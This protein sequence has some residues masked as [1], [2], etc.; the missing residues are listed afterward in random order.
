MTD[1]TVD[2]R[3]APLPGVGK[4]LVAQTRY[5]FRL[6]L[7]TP[8]ALT[9]GVGLPVVLLLV[10]NATGGSIDIPHLA[11]LAV[12]G[13]SITAWSTHGIN[14]VA[15]R[16]A[17]VLKRWR[18][19]PLP[20]WCYFG[21]RI[22]ATVLVA[23]MGGAVTVLAGVALYGAPLDARSAVGVLLALAL[24]ALAWAAPATA[25]TG[26]IPNVESA[27]PIMSLTYLPVVLI[28][29][30]FGTLGTEPGWLARIA[31]ALPAQPLIDAVTRSLQHHAVPAHDLVVLAAWAG[32]GLVA[33]LL[34]FRW[35]PH[36]PTQRRAARS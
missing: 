10:S 24:G 15:A 7:S 5:Q 11:G 29:G 31:R 26:L 8:R 30:V 34:L 27:W 14:L 17:G 32:A 18:A 28:S 25:L 23:V 16:E 35:E 19:T 12:L 22:A 2:T 13:L 3:L 33:A 9:A 36:R 21:G 6:L 4:L 1:I 20:A